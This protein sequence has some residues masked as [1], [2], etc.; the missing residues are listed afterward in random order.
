MMIDQKK[1][2]TAKDIESLKMIMSQ[3]GPASERTIRRMMTD[4]ELKPITRNIGRGA[5]AQW[6]VRGKD[7]IV[8]LNITY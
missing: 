5:R 4:G 7:L 8:Y 3:R 2:Y 1:K 6:I